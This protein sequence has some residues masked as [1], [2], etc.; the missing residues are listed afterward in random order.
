MN[1][2]NEEHE[3]SPF[4]MSKENVRGQEN[5][6]MTSLLEKYGSLAMSEAV[7]RQGNIDNKY[8]GENREDVTEGEGGHRYE[9]KSALCKRG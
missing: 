2:F 4:E 5:Q 9:K 1:E 8:Y 3:Q 7:P 6:E